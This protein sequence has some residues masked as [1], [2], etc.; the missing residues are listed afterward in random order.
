MPYLELVCTT[1]Q[2]SRYRSKIEIDPTTKLV[3][4]IFDP[5]GDQPPGETY[6]GA[7]LCYNCNGKLVPMPISNTNKRPRE[8]AA[9]L[10]D[11]KAQEKLNSDDSPPEKPQ[12][13][14]FMREI[15]ACAN[16]EGN[17]EMLNLS[18]G[19]VLVKTNRRLIILN[20]KEAISE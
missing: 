1:C 10:R 6:K 16:D 8:E 4:E 2:E 7:P 14:D 20:L 11:L 3:P 15:F 18:D 17:M 9:A 12:N 5:L 13:H 19:R